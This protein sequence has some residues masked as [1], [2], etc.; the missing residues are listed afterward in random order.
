M[1][2]DAL[3]RFAAEVGAIG[4]VAR[5]LMRVGSADDL[6]EASVALLDARAKL[7]TLRQQR[8]PP[9]PAPEY[10]ATPDALVAHAFVQALL[11]LVEAGEAVRADPVGL[12]VAGVLRLTREME[13]VGADLHELLSAR[14]QPQ[15]GRP[16][17]RLFQ[18]DGA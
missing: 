18:D 1:E 9:P 17:L 6:T 12:P 11:R 10:N 4:E 7:Q 13:R 8:T 2:L 3:E 15:A 5:E 16:T 14:G